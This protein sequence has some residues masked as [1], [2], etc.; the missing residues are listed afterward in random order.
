VTDV[1]RPLKAVRSLARIQ[2]GRRTCYILPWRGTAYGLASLAIVFG[3]LLAVDRFV[4]GSLERGGWTAGQQWALHNKIIEENNRRKTTT[5]E[6]EPRWWRGQPIRTDASRKILV[7]GDS[8]VWGPPYIT[9]NHLWWRQLAIELE[10]RGYREVEVVA[11]GHPGWSTHRQ[12][13]CAS[14]LIPELKPDLVIWGYVTND[15]DE[16][17]VRQIFDTQDRPPFGQRIRRKL[18]WLLP[19]VEFKFESLRNDKLSAQY[20]GPK[21]GYAYPDWELKLVEGKNFSRYHETVQQVGELMRQTDIPSFL[22]TLPHFPS[23]EYFEPRYDPVLPLWQAAKIPVLDTLGA[24]VEK[25]GD[26]SPT[27]PAAIAWGI[28]PADSH[29]GP[30]ATHFFATQAADFIERSWGDVL[31][32]K[33]AK[34]PHELVINDWLPNDLDVHPIATSKE[35]FELDYPFTTVHMPQLPSPPAALVAFRYPTPLSSVVFGGEHVTNVH[36]WA[37]FQPQDDFED[38]NWHELKPAREGFIEYWMPPDFIDRPVSALRLSADTQGADRHLQL[39]VVPA[40]MRRAARE[41][42]RSQ[43]T[44]E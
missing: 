20:T 7:M 24:F 41:A 3:L 30:K 17:I 33:D 2:V 21:Y 44:P 22:I 39:L 25:Y 35:I 23:R 32:L 34:Q 43:T 37:L 18:Q 28:N 16:K 15:P 10:R 12:L 5:N 19:N 38:D 36:V 42:A 4:L 6:C 8:F 9:L 1:K 26:F 14:H 13:E 40:E 27:S 31:G 29:P 11:V